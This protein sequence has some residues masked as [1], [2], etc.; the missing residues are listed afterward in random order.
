MTV[1]PLRAVGAVA[2]KVGIV[3]L[4]PV[5]QERH[6]DAGPVEA[7]RLGRSGVYLLEGFG[8]QFGVGPGA[9]ELAGGRHAMRSQPGLV[10]ARPGGEVAALGA[11]GL[12]AA[13]LED[14]EASG[15]SARTSEMAGDLPRAA[16]RVGLTAAVTESTKLVVART[17]APS[18]LSAART[19]A[20]AGQAAPADVL[21]RSGQAWRSISMTLCVAGAPLFTAACAGDGGASALSAARGW[22]TNEAVRLSAAPVRRRAVRRRAVRRRA[23]R[24][25]AVRY[26]ARVITTHLPVLVVMPPAC[27]S[28]P[29]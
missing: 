12:G 25:R 5:G 18:A 14:A 26:L 4:D 27:R 13:E 10:V 9:A 22:A 3:G 2:H 7:H 1:R 6:G 29:G 16:A 23:V 20:W 11:G 15:T 28:R 17:L 19:G 8:V 24:R 21:A